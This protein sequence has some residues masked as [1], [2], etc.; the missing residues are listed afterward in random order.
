MIG[1]CQAISRGCATS[2]SVHPLALSRLPLHLLLAR[3]P[4]ERRGLVRIIR[5]LDHRSAEIALPGRL[6][7]TTAWSES[8]GPPSG[9]SSIGAGEA[10]LR[11]S[12]S[13]P[14]PDTRGRG[15]ASVISRL[16]LRHLTTLGARLRC[17]SSLRCSPS[18]TP[19]RRSCRRCQDTRRHG[20]PPGM[21]HRHR[22]PTGGCVR[23]ARWRASRARSV[24][25]FVA[26]LPTSRSRAGSTLSSVLPVAGPAPAVAKEAPGWL[27]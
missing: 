18:P 6:L 20:S 11:A 8:H 19:S 12:C 25:G 15:I 16:L 27:D 1:R 17:I 22:N 23:R 21:P 14:A 3:E 2:S 4:P 9:R 5:M 24:A 26:I 10:H 13:S 7:P